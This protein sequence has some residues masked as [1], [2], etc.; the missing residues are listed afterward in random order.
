MRPVCYGL[1]TAGS[2]LAFTGRRRH[3]DRARSAT[4]VS[5]VVAKIHR[6]AASAPRWRRLAV[7]RSTAKGPE[8][9][10]RIATAPLR[11]RRRSVACAPDLGPRSARSRPYG[12]PGGRSSLTAVVAGPVR[13]VGHH[14]SVACGAVARPPLQPVECHRW[15]YARAKA[16]SHLVHR[17]RPIPPRRSAVAGSGAG[18]HDRKLLATVQNLGIHAHLPANTCEPAGIRTQDTRIKSPL[19]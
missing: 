3:R 1:R 6:V 9:L 2:G 14:G 13:G 15:N 8:Q 19:L 11:G 5:R 12:L 4:I 7:D 10:T 18:R 16:S 17:D